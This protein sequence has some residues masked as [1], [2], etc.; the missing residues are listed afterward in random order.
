VTGP[1]VLVSSS[2]GVLLDVLALEPWW[3]R[4]D[5]RWVAVRAPD[6]VDVLASSP[7]TWLPEL[8]PTRPDRVARATGVALQQLR[9]W[10]PLAV[11]SAGSGVAVP[12]FV[13][14]RAL[15]VPALW[16]ETYNVVGRPGLASR[17]AASLATAVV[18][19]HPELVARHRRCVYVGELL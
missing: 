11:L 17:V 13:A 5:T 16:V 4:Y 1:V 10:R 2:G 18:V 6:T 15:G 19:Q 9:R 7:V 14:A 3:G 12:Y 8:V